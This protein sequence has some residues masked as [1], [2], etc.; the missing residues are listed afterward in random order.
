MKKHVIAAVL[1]AC[2]FP[3]TADAKKKK[4]PVW[5]AGQVP[6]PITGTT[7]CTIAATD[8]ASK[9]RFTRTGA[10]YPGVEFNSEHGLLVGVS[11][12]GKYRMP[13]G[14][15]VWRVDDRPFHEI[16]A[17]DNPV[18][19]SVAPVLAGVSERTMQVT[20]A[21]TNRMVAA[22]TATST[23]ASGDKA[24]VMLA[25][26]LEGHGLIFRSANVQ[27][28]GLADPRAHEVGQITKG[29]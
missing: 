15:I 6:D 1:I 22:M 13:T 8:R 11:S 16:K 4:E 10:T 5:A 23:M 27:S 3:T 17:A 20:L 18:S 9:V 14:D 25:E 19:G 12:G 26:M 2:T 28:F 21:E 29:G 7:R 24:K